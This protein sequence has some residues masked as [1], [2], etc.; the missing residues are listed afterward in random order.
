[1]AASNV[2]AICYN[3]PEDSTELAIIDSAVNYIISNGKFLLNAI[4]FAGSF[5]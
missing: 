4:P 1:M 3:H 5:G 2:A